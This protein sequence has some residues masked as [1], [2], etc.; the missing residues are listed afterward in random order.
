MKR[1]LNIECL[2]W[3]V[4]QII[5]PFWQAYCVTNYL[6]IHPIEHL[7]RKEYK[8][9]ELDEIKYKNSEETEA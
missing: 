9:C 5:G 1:D 7:P 4:N 8:L 3:K 2:C 6:K